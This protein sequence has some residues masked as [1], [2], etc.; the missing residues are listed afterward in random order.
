MVLI[1]QIS[2]PVWTKATRENNAKYNSNRNISHTPLVKKR[3]FKPI[4]PNPLLFS[5]L[6]KKQNKHLQVHTVLAQFAR[7]KGKDT[8]VFGSYHLYLM[9]ANN[10]KMQ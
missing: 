5:F 3:K 7:Q 4:V 1:M 9:K 2:H 10:T 6:L 8:L